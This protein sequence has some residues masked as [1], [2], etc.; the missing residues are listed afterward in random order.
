MICK[1]KFIP[2]GI[3]EKSAS[4]NVAISSTVIA[5]DSEDSASDYEVL[6]IQ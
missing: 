2:F 1:R 3:V 6:D 5:A 4:R